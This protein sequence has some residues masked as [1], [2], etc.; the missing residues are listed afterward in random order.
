MA[1]K[2]HTKRWQR[3][4]VFIIAMLFILTSAALTIAVIFQAASGSSNSSTNSSKNQ[5]TPK[6]LAGT[7]LAGFTPVS[8]VP[9]LQVTDLKKGTGPAVKAGQTITVDYTGAVA[10]TGIIFQSTKDLGQPATFQLSGVIQGWQQGIPG[11]QT[12]GVR[13]LVIPASEAYGASPPQ[14]SGI[15]PNAPLVFDVTLDKIDK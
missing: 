3:V 9:T 13:Q 8:S 14:G 6:Q 12:G 1:E 5:T 10:A 2:S 15:P 4:S 11:M 7:K